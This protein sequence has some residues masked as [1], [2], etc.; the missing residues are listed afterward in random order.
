[1][2]FYLRNIIVERCSLLSLVHVSFS[3]ILIISGAAA[4]LPTNMGRSK[5]DECSKR[6]QN[7]SPL[8]P[9]WALCTCG[10]TP[11]SLG[12][13]LAR[14]EPLAPYKCLQNSAARRNSSGL[15]G[16]KPYHCIVF[17]SRGVQ[18]VASVPLSKCMTQTYN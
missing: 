10:P 8:L 4:A 16:D 18:F 12:M 3:G 14:D 1:M 2:T 13:H 6:D 11:Y 17:C 5:H 7:S 15:D 9:G